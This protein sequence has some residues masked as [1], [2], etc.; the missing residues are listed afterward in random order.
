MN[1]GDTIALSTDGD[2]GIVTLTDVQGNTTV[3]EGY[4]YLQEE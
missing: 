1:T 4:T 2:V 3:Y